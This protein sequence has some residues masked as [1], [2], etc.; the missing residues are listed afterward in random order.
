MGVSFI[1]AQHKVALSLD[2]LSHPSQISAPVTTRLLQRSMG[3]RRRSLLKRKRCSTQVGTPIYTSAPRD[4][5]GIAQIIQSQAHKCRSH[6][7]LKPFTTHIH[8]IPLTHTC[9]DPSDIARRRSRLSSS[10]GFRRKRDPRRR[11]LRRMQDLFP[12]V[13]F[14]VENDIP[15]ATPEMR[16]DGREGH[17]RGHN[18][19]AHTRQRST[20]ALHRD[21]R[22]PT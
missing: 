18:L 21:D 10:S 14:V 12:P 9:R 15:A 22:R 1:L 3:A 4:K 5:V 6:I 16:A 8:T 11:L 20:Q 2:C 17:G 13:G 7:P 19:H